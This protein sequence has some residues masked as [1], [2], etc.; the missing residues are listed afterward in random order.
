MSIYLK[1]YKLFTSPGILTQNLFM[2]NKKRVVLRTTAPS[3]GCTVKGILFFLRIICDYKFVYVDMLAMYFEMLLPAR[4]C[5]RRG[6]LK[7]YALVD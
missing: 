4:L 7:K 2:W 6:L 3:I 5:T 1:E